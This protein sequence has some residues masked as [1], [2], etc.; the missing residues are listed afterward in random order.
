MLRLVVGFLPWIILGVLGDRWFVLALVLALAAATVT[1]VRQVSRG[2]LKILDTTTFAFFLFVLVSVVGFR[3][4]ACD[5]HV[6]PRERDVDGDSVGL[7]AR[8]YALYH[9]VCA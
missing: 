8:R 2:S 6:A 5:P 1:T 3:W 4:M 9:S 7:S